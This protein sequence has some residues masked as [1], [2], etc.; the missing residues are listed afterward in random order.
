[1]ELDSLKD[2]WK[3]AGVS[4]LPQTPDIRTLIRQRSQNSLA[5]MQRNLRFEVFLMLFLYGAM[6]VYYF[7]GFGGKFSYLSWTLI[8]LVSFYFVYFFYKNRL[9]NQMRK[10]GSELRTTLETQLKTLSNYLR[11]Y[12]VSG[13]LLV[14][15]ILIFTY[16]VAFYNRAPEKA[17]PG[18]GLVGGL[19]LFVVLITIAAYYIN[20]WYVRKL[21]GRHI[22]HIKR[23]LEELRTE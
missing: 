19:L 4:D 23:I 21:Y 3:Q 14:P 8:G 10:G 18:W 22:N 7:L 2:I 13:T 5:R 17:F 1:M 15:V 20:K 16:G 9:L 11:F 12:L 6:A